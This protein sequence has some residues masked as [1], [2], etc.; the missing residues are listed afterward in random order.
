MDA[1]SQAVSIPYSCGQVAELM[2]DGS[3]T[4]QGLGK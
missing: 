3:C 4:L 1:V 2:D